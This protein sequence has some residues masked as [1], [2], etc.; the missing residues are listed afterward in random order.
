MKEE[1]KRTSGQEDKKTNGGGRR[2]VRR[3]FQTEA[4]MEYAGYTPH[5]HAH[6]LKTSAE[7]VARVGAG[8][9]SLLLLLPFLFNILFMLLSFS[10]YFHFYAL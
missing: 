7:T 5:R 3:A 1:E 2:R 6:R 10:L 4:R 9:V 8:T